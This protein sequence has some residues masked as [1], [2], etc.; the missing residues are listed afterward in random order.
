MMCGLQL[1]QGFTQ[2]V[3][4]ANK[5]WVT[6][7]IVI[8]LWMITMFFSTP[9]HYHDEGPLLTPILKNKVP[10]RQAQ[11]A[12]I[13][14]LWKYLLHRYGDDQAVRIYSNLMFVYMKMQIVG[15]GIYT[16]LRTKVE[17]RATHET[18]VKLVVVDTG[19]EQ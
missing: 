10:V 2:V 14:L 16:Q 1:Y 17:L 3:G 7:R 12:Y 4:L 6:D 8:R 15:F 11:N 5:F 18:L 19:E 13:T 9:L